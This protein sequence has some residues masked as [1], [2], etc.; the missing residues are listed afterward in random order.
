MSHHA[1]PRPRLRR[2]LDTLGKREFKQTIFFMHLLARV[3]GCSESLAPKTGVLMPLAR[4]KALERVPGPNETEI[5][6]RAGS[7][8]S[9]LAFSSFVTLRWRNLWKSGCWENPGSDRSQQTSAL[10]RPAAI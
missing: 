9:L 4:V 3:R 2:G 5:K 1:V 7:V 6:P 10:V 8:A